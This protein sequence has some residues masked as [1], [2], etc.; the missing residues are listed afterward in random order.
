VTAVL[1]LAVIT[2]GYCVG[3]VL[4]ADT[5]DDAEVEPTGWIVEHR[6]GTVRR[7]CTPE[8]AAFYASTAH[9]VTRITPVW[10]DQP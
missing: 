1:V 6:D 3:A 4:A 5:T 8:I 10:E 9:G 7:C 2:V